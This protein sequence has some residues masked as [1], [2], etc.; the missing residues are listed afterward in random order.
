VL[1]NGDKVGDTDDMVEVVERV[2]DNETMEGDI[3]D[4][5]GKSLNSAKS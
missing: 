5:R 3:L 4:R 1:G 2:G